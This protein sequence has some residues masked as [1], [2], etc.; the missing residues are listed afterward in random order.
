MNRKVYKM[1]EAA[2]K[3]DGVEE[4]FKLEQDSPTLDIFSRQYRDILD[5]ITMP[6]TKIK[7]LERLLRSVIGD[8]KK[9]N[10]VKATE[11]TER[12]NKLVD[13]YNEM[14]RKHPL[15]S[16]AYEEITKRIS[17]LFEDIEDDKN[18]FEEMNI[19]IGQK[20][21]YDILKYCAEK[22]DFEYP[23]EKLIILSEK[24]IEL[25]DEK[26]AFGDWKNTA[27]KAELEAGLIVLL[28]ENGYPPIPQDEV[29]NDV[30]EQAENYGKYN[31][32]VSS[33]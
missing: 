22:Y 31:K 23:H 28:D 19:T 14:R 12:L 3:S 2:I 6:N 7:L 10:K 32:A 18:S 5:K 13:E 20:A 16:K 29:I 1:L 11:F 26:T 9:V 8:Y 24:V 15:A 30:F 33:V 27:R 17:E 25:V 21:F 4:V